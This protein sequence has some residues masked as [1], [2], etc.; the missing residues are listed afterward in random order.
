MRPMWMM[1]LLLTVVLLSPVAALGEQRWQCGDGLSVPLQGS[2]VDRDEACRKLKEKRDTPP[3]SEEQ[4]A[5]LRQRVEELEKRYELQPG[6]AE[7]VD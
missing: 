4:A 1:Q 7:K 3:M 2:R 6:D 5:R